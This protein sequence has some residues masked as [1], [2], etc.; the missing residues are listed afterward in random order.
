[1][2]SR[3]L[4]MAPPTPPESVVRLPESV[5]RLSENVLLVTVSAPKLSMAPA[6]S[7]PVPLLAENVLL[8]TVSVPR[9]RMPPEPARAIVVE[10]AV[11]DR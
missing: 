3:R 4:K 5:A 2:E 10:G 9:L 8:V 11:G 7:P 6:L 1:M